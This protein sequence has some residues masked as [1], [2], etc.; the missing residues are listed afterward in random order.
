MVKQAEEFAEADKVKKEMVETVNQAES[1]IHDIESKMEEFKEQLPA[2]EVAELRTEITTVKDL[3]AKKDELENPEE[4]RE[5]F[6]KLQ[7]KSLK[8]FEMAYKKMAADRESSG[9]SGS[10]DSEQQ[11]QK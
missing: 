2:D 10:D 5:A 4:L 7:Q 9:S 1:A 3:I 8:L 6:Q 11:S